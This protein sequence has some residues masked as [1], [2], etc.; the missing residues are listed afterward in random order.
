MPYTMCGQKRGV[1]K[2]LQHMLHISHCPQLPYQTI[3][4]SRMQERVV[5]INPL[6]LDDYALKYL[7]QEK[8]Q[9]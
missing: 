2:D 9:N 4:S 1:P 5:Y 3:T 8:G 7:Y 6:P